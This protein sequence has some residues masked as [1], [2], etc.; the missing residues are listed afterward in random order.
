MTMQSPEVQALSSL[1]L[2]KQTPPD[3]LQELLDASRVLTFQTGDR[4][5][6]VGEPSDTALLVITGRLIV[7]LPEGDG[8]YRLGDVRPG[9]ITGET[10]LLTND[11]RR[12]AS[13]CVQEDATCLELTQELL[14]VIADSP[15]VIALEQHLMGTMARRI[16]EINTNIQ[17]A[18]R[19]TAGS[20]DSEETGVTVLLGRLRTFFR[21]A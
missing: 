7:V 17:K 2:F 1:Y 4:I 18:T 21:G 6:G 20:E 14:M 15:A 9:E 3:A 10:A 19:I 13:L 16:R 12:G 5:F 8:E 11:G